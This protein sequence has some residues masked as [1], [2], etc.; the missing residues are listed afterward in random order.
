MIIDPHIAVIRT[1]PSLDFYDGVLARIF[2]REEQPRGVLM[3]YSAI[4]KDEM[5]ATTVFT[6]R[7][8]M[9]EAFIGFTALESENEMR[10]SGERFDLDRTEYELERL[11]IWPQVPQDAFSAKPAGKMVAISS[12]LIDLTP[13]EYRRIERS[14]KWGERDVPGRL[15][16]LAFKRGGAMY[17]T[18]FWSDREAGESFYRELHAASD[19]SGLPSRS[20]EQ[21]FADSW[22]DVH[23]FVVT[24]AVD[25]PIR[26]FTRTVDGPS[27]TRPSSG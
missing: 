7:V 18:T 6:D 14:C 23:T 17:T 26:D 9:R 25:H 22:M 20:S 12:E 19:S 3:H 4:F 15:A 2:L 1:R 11:H 16:H 13:E 24:L 10:E 21:R 8:A 27:N 5:I